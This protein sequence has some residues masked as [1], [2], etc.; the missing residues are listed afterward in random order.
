[1]AAQPNP[2]RQSPQPAADI[3]RYGSAS[4]VPTTPALDAT[5]APTE[6]TFA[7]SWPA[8]QAA[9]DRGELAQAHQL[10][11]RWYA[12]PSHT[13]TDSERVESL[14]SQLAG[15]VVYSTEHQL[16]P[17]H[18][19]KPGETLES[20]AKEYSVPWQL[21][22]KING[23]AAPNQVR[24]GQELKVV[25]GPFS[26]VV[27]LGRNQL[28][29]MVDGRYAGKFPV[30]VVPGQSVSDGQWVVDQKLP[31]AE[32]AIV[33]RREAAS[34]DATAASPSTLTIASGAPSGAATADSTIQVSAKDA[35]ELSDILSIGSRVVTRR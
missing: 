9:L 32:P 29:L 33:L 23:I 13:P 6:P 31:S 2:L 8:I 7:A 28:T 26:A 35:E 15:T 3:G 4:P 14:L 16:A 5:I 27:D 11:S 10:L 21:L 25:R 1:L 18:V 20:V 17:A 19:V 24:P 30:S 22:A 34:P 12:D